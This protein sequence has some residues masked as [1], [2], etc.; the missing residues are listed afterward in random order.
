MIRISS[1]NANHITKSESFL[2]NTF[3]FFIF[4]SF[5]TGFPI[6]FGGVCRTILGGRLELLLLLVQL[7]I[8]AIHQSK[9]PFSFSNVNLKYSIYFS[10]ALL[11]IYILGAIAIGELDNILIFSLLHVFFLIF[12]RD[13]LKLVCLHRFI[14][15][16]GVLL[17]LSLIE[18]LVLLFFGKGILVMSSVIK[19][20]TENND[21]AEVFDQYLLNFIFTGWGSELP[22]FQSLCEEPG[23]I[24]TICGLLTFVTQ[25][26]K[27][28]RFEY[29]VFVLSGFFSFSL[30]FYALF[31]I[32]LIQNIG[33]NKL[34]IIIAAIISLIAIYYLYDFIE[35][36]IMRRFMEDNLDNRL[37]YDF[38]KRF[39][40]ALKD[41][42]LWLPQG[43]SLGS[44]GAGAKMWIWKHGIISLI[45]F[46]SFYYNYYWKKV[47]SYNSLFWPCLVFFFAFWIS[48]YQRHWI[49][50][51]E[52]MIIYM[53]VPVLFAKNRQRLNIDI[54]KKHKK[55]ERD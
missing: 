45:I 11:S 54:N 38:N 20:G 13:D 28:Y 40:D 48:F 55:N 3:V 30:A 8:C 36:R 26:K 18:F 2:V 24:G 53:S 44:H 25:R 41:G 21:F 7:V 6:A 43:M 15:V 12:L 49:T 34:A 4:W 32:S 16:L 17:C 22:R 14:K 50:N 31:A 46:F 9:Y 51:L 19:V 42:S 29:I 47:K 33:H 10:L 23:N 27:E 5:F 1:E 52:Y 37:T 39:M 35:Y